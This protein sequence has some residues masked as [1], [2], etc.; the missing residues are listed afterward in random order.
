MCTTDAS[1]GLYH[2]DT[3]DELDH[4]RRDDTQLLIHLDRL[5]THARHTQ[6]HRRCVERKRSD[7]EQAE[8]PVDEEGV[9]HER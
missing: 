1:K 4:T 5:F 8:P 9:S 3:G 7:G 6:A 2:R